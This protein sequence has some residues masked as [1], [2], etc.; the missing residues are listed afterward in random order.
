MA[1]PFE[2]NQVGVSLWS[3]KDIEKREKKLK[4]EQDASETS[5]NGRNEEYME[6]DN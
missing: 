2:S 5:G 3:V 4:A 1:Q 6:I